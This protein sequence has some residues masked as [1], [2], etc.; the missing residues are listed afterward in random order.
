MVTKVEIMQNA[1]SGKPIIER[2]LTVDTAK[3]LVAKVLGALGT[4]RCLLLLVPEGGIEPPRAQ[5]SLDFESSA[6]TSSATPA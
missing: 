3:S 4:P 6:S 1:K 5:G 2:L